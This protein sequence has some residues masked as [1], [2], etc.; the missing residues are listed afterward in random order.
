M[1]IEETQALDP[2][3]KKFAEKYCRSV[4]HPMMIVDNLLF[5]VYSSHPKLVPVGTLISMFVKDPVETPLKREKDAILIFKDV[6][7]CARFT[8]IDN[9]HSFCELID[10]SSILTMAAYTDLYSVM[11]QRFGLLEECTANIRKYVRSLSEGLAPKV[12]FKNMHIM[13]LQAE[14]LK[15]DSLLNDICEYSYT[16]FSTK[17]FDEVID[18]YAL[19]ELLIKQS[20]SYLEESG[21]YMEFVSE[22]DGYFI[23]TNQRFAITAI[24]H[25]VQNALLYSPKDNVPVISLTRSVKDGKRYVV[26]QVVNDLDEYTVKTLDGEPDFV[27]RRCGLGIPLI[28]KFTQRAGGEFYFKTS[29]KKA[30]VGIMIPEYVLNETETFTME[31]SGFSIYDYGGKNIIKLMMEDV[32]SSL[33]KKK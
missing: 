25:A 4:S 17:G 26:V 13:D 24:L 3:L 10:Y 23:Y 12:R 20:N 5:V 9:N 6:T 14:S 7:Y 1:T 32:V 30:S 11:S 29:G 31:R 27:H 16:A 8:P 18:S 19:I 33:S 2:Q 15:M 21:K 22:L 28:K